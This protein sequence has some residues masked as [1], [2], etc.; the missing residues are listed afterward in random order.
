MGRQRWG[1][2]R[3]S[4]RS[5]DCATSV[6]TAKRRRGDAGHRNQVPAPVQ[7]ARQQKQSADIAWRSQSVRPA[8]V[9]STLR[10]CAE[11]KLN[12]C[13]PHLPKV[14]FRH[15]CRSCHTWQR[16][17][18]LFTVLAAWCCCCPHRAPHCCCIDCPPCWRCS[19]PCSV[20]AASGKG[21]L[22][23][24]SGGTGYEHRCGVLI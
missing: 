5:C 17:R 21:W 8:A 11:W 4:T 14:L 13:H 1:K 6:I 10:L 20:A 24:R 9:P 12:S 2:L 3:A 22:S 19:P 23:A 15:V 16:R 7:G 18:Q